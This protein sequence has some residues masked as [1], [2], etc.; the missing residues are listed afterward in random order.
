MTQYDVLQGKR[1]SFGLFVFNAS[2][3]HWL[4]ENVL[5]TTKLV[6]FIQWVVNAFPSTQLRTEHYIQDYRQELYE[7]GKKHLP[8]KKDNLF[9]LTAL[10]KSILKILWIIWLLIRE[11]RC[12]YW[13]QDLSFSSSNIFKWPPLPQL[14]TSY[15]EMCLKQMH[16]S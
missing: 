8:R 5:W 15:L 13:T 9:M 12:T 7:K 11:T 1:I 16:F 6:H 14:K 10:W 2:Y 3:Y 4:L